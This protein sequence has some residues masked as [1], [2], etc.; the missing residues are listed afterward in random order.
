MFLGDKLFSVDASIEEFLNYLR[1][2]KGLA[3]GTLEGY[4]RDLREFAAYAAEHGC[5]SPV[6]LTASVVHS[7][8]SHLGAIGLA[9]RTIH[10]RLSPLRT[11]C[12]YLVREGFMISDPT[13]ELEPL[14][15]GRRLPKALTV[16]EMRALIQ[17][18]GPDPVQAIRDRAIIELMYGSGLRVAEAAGLD[19]SDVD[20]QERTVR[21]RGK[22]GKDRVVPF[23]A[24]AA[25]ALE[26]YLGSVRGRLSRGSDSALF[27]TRLGRRFSTSGLWRLIKE[28]ARAAGITRPVSPHTLRHSFATHLLEGGADL[29]VVQELL[30]HASI[31]TTEIYTH[32]TSDHLREVY[33]AS[34]PRA[35][36]G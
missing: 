10:R 31:A 16:E 15:L 4:A 14:K 24:P 22:G 36:R 23:G 25:E 3:E 19:V 30:G 27:L 35:R 21:C 12:R 6:E 32:V 29:R 11:F 18:E 34:H 13:E 7:Y 5:T 20:L 8:A 1:V 33:T 26:A 2:E 17:Y 9:P 28:R